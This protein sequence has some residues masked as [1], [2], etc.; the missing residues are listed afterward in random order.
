MSNLDF[1][2]L[3]VKVIQENDTPGF[4]YIDSDPMPRKDQV[5]VLAVDGQEIV[6]LKVVFNPLA[7]SCSQI[8]RRNTFS[9]C[10]SEMGR[11]ES[12]V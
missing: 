6:F 1:T 7:R 8:D 11:W 9:R 12:T 10:L 3:Y 5:Y 4:S 2:M